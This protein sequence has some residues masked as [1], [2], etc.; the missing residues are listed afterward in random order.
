V[1][2]STR[3]TR[4]VSALCFPDFF[5]K[6]T[7]KAIK[8]GTHLFVQP[9][10]LLNLTGLLQP[11]LDI[12]SSNWVKDSFSFAHEIQQLNTDLSNSFLCSF[13]ISN[14]FTNVP[15]AET[16]QIC[17]DTLYN[18]KLILPFIELLNTATFSVEFS[19]NNTMYKW[20]EYAF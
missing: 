3:D 18:G 11:V 19:F 17:A 10:F 14:L 8:K 20:G 9:L 2:Y 7:R 12:Y 15:L 1:Q 16:I 4:V 13:D 6:K 5:I